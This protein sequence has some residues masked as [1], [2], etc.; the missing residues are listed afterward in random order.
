M[1]RL[2]DIGVAVL[3]LLPALVIVALA[4]LIVFVREGHSPFFIQTRLGR[5]E[6]KFQMYKVRT[7]DPLTES[8]AT[9]QVPDHSVTCTG[10]VIRKLKIDELPQLINVISGQ[11]SLVGPRPGLPEQTELADA[12]RKLGVFDVVPG[13]TGFG[14]VQGVDM[15]EPEHLAQLD[16]EYIKTQSLLKDAL[17]MLQTLTRLGGKKPTH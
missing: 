10:R 17:I 9:H 15:S 3:L 14:Q 8:V 16:A 7:M 5:N 1:K 2:F 6:T 12:R 4:A 13:M 11:M